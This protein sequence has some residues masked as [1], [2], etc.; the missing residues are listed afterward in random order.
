[1]VDKENKFYKNLHNEGIIHFKNIFKINKKKFHYGWGSYL[2]NGKVYKYDE[3]MYEKQKLLFD[4]S[5]KSRK[6]LE[7]GVYMGHSILIMLLA[8]PKV[9]ITAIDISD[10]YSKPS[11]EY[12]KKKFPKSKINLIIGDSRKE[13]KNLKGNFDLIHLDSSHSLKKSLEEFNLLIKL[14]KKKIF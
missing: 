4:L 2:F 14:K 1:M 8:N 6:I 13:I 9:H 11:I 7:I 10:V 3:G 5:K 12:L